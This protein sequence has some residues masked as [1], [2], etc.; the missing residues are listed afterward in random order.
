MTGEC[1]TVWYSAYVRIVNHL[2]VH[3]CP[4]SRDGRRLVS[5]GCG[6]GIYSMEFPPPSLPPA[7]ALHPLPQSLTHSITHSHSLSLLLSL[8]L[9]TLCV[10]FASSIYLCFSPTSCFYI[11]VSILLYMFSHTIPSIYPSIL[12]GRVC[13][14]TPLRWD[15]LLTTKH[16]QY[17][18]VCVWLPLP[19]PVCA[20][21]CIL[22]FGNAA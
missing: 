17:P 21:A 4:F 7:R 8:S 11:C 1:D 15:V 22:S 18:G 10:S 6:Y 9:L 14:C 16:W 2:L 3:V 13:A 12:C 19:T 20:C 5:D